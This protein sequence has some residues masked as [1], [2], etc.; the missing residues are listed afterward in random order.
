MPDLQTYLDVFVRGLDK[1]AS[2]KS[3][4]QGQTTIPF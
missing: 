2:K 1:C 3:K 4:L